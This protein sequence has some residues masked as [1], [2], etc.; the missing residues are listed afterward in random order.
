MRWRGGKEEGRGGDEEEGEDK[1]E[2][3][4]EVVEHGG[5]SSGSMVVQGHDGYEG[6]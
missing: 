5:L 6:V 3:K 2:R 1:E 4:E